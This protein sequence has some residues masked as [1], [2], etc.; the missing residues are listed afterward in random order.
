MNWVNSERFPCPCDS[1]NADPY[2]AYEQSVW[3]LERLLAAG[4][5]AELETISGQATDSKALIRNGPRSGP[6]SISTNSSKEKTP[7]RHI[8]ISDHGPT[9][10][11]RRYGL[12]LW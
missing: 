6:L 7:Q 9:G 12:A 2:V 8:L 11:N 10:R 4:V 5:P 1:R 3:L